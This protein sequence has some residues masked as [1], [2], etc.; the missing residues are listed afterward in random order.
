[1][2]NKILKAFAFLILF[3][4]PILFYIFHNHKE[5]PFKHRLLHR[6]ENRAVTVPSPGP[7]VIPEPIIVPKVKK[8]PR[9]AIIFDDLGENLKEV[10]EL[11]SLNIP[12]TASV[13]PGLKFSSQSAA[14][15]ER[16]GFSVFIHM[17]MEPEGAAEF[18]TK[19]YTFISASQSPREVKSLL[20]YYL[21]S[22]PQAIGVNNHMGSAAT[23]N[24][25]LM[26]TVMRAVKQRNLIFVDSRTSP[27]SVAYST[28]VSQG[29]VAGI[30]D[31]FVDAA[32]DTGL[33]SERLDFLA[34]K[35]AEQGKIIIIAHPRKR[36]FA[37]LKAKLPSLKTK[38]RFVTIKD[39]FSN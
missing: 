12:L 19:K 22:L 27:N 11:Y 16:C 18:R 7:V 30:N 1:M 34:R 33:I 21:S 13:I 26:E 2:L 36:T 38:V 39:Y 14:M 9:I 24:R 25:P 5:G 28:A 23:A 35:A 20:R 37:V 17:P 10:G 15:A 32:D 4:I 3:S 6:H 8:L 31:G 29:L